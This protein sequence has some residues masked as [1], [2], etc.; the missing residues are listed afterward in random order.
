MRGSSLFFSLL[1][2]LGVAGFFLY[3]IFGYC[4]L[5]DY[6]TQEHRAAPSESDAI[7]SGALF[8]CLA[9]LMNYMLINSS[10][11]L[12]LT[13]MLFAAAIRYENIAVKTED[14]SSMP[15]SYENQP[16]P[17]NGQHRAVC[18]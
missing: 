13:F 10:P 15:H 18:S 16:A 6:T 14:L 8:G 11:D 2:T 9:L 3:L 5:R 1:G 12:G 4:L 7:R 17:R